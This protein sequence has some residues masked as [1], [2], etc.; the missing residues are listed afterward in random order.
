MGMFVS[1][2]AVFCGAP[3]NTA[4][5]GVIWCQKRQIDDVIGRFD[6]SFVKLTRFAG[7]S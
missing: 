5:L 6:Y 1:I 7:T 3:A 4:V 2:E